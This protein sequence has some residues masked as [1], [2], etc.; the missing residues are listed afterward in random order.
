MPPSEKSRVPVTAQVLRMAASCSPIE[1]P[2]RIPD[3]PTAAARLLGAGV[4]YQRVGGEREQFVEQEQS[5]QV[6][7]KATPKVQAMAMAKAA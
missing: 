7:E 2:R 5:E 1:V 3:R 4:G 6:A